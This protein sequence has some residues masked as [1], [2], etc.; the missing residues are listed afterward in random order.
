MLGGKPLYKN[1]VERGIK[2]WC[3]VHFKIIRELSKKESI[4]HQYTVPKTP[5][6]NGVAEKNESDIGSN[7]TS[8]V[9]GFEVN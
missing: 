6:H 9:V 8:Y 4:H 1:P 3:V 2:L 7:C 5:E